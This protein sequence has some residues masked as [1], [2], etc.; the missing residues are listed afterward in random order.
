MKV[1]DNMEATTPIFETTGQAIHVAFTILAEDAQQDCV[2]RKALIRMLEQIDPHCGWLEQLR[3]SPSETVH[4][5]G[6]NSYDVRAQ[7]ALIMVAV[8]TRLP[9]TEMWALQAKYCKTDFEGPRESRRYAFSKEKIDAV[10]GL[11]EWL[12]ESKAFGG[13]P[14]LAIDC[15][16]AKYY[17]RHK[18]TEISFRELAKSF[19]GNHMQY[20]RA[21]PKIKARLKPLEDMAV[22]RL[23]PYFE[24]Q[25]IV[26]RQP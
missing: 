6:L 20:A 4:F 18:K 8:R 1:I 22:E 21:F 11:S 13:I 10:K 5:G 9:K 15:I 2:L 25:G 26:A 7:C 12:A 16:V 14:L 19:G 3:G 23:R 24:E 17:A